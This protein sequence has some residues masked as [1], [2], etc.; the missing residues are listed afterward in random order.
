VLAA[1]ELPLLAE[2]TV[3]QDVERL[4]VVGSINNAQ[5]LSPAELQARLGPAVCQVGRLDDDALASGG[6]QFQPP[7]GGLGTR[8]L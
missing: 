6:G 8:L 5:V 4:C 2:V 1:G 7:V 3:A